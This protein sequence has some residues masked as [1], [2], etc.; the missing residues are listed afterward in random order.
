MY[1]PQGT[2]IMNTVHGV[3]T[4][5]ISDK[6]NFRSQHLVKIAMLTL[7]WDI[8][9]SITTDVHEKGAPVTSSSNCQFLKQNSLSI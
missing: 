9:E 6:E 1:L 8:N 5:W 2:R 4:Y 7:L 3:E